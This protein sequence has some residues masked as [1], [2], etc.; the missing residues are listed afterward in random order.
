MGNITTYVDVVALAFFSAGSNVITIDIHLLRIFFLPYFAYF[1]SCIE[2]YSEIIFWFGKDYT[3]GER[4]ACYGSFGCCLPFIEQCAVV[5][6][7]YYFARGA[8]NNSEHLLSVVER[9][10]E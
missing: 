8:V 9:V 2:F 1:V 6:L 5:V 7:I 4:T 10:Y 3:F